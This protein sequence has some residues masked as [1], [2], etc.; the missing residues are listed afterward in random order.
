MGAKINEYPYEITSIG[1]NDYFD[2]DSWNGANYQSS[3]LSGNS[4]KTQVGN[5]VPQRVF[6]SFYDTTTQN[7]TS[8]TITAMQTNNSDTWN[9]GVS[10][11]NDG[12]GN[13]SVYRVSK[14][15]VYNVMFSAQLYRTSGGSAKTVTI[16]LKKNGVDVANTAT[17]V[18]VQANAG[19]LVAAWNFFIN[20]DTTDD[21]QIMWTQDDAIQLEYQTADGILPH[22]AVP[23]LIV[24][25]NEV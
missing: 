7:C 11:S 25:I 15:G 12:I 18:N 19:R 14:N 5:W 8:G 3:K 13:P 2:V 10:V 23:S 20:I 22:P 16:W 6:G 9:N 17:N 24:T 21:L 4:L 1:A